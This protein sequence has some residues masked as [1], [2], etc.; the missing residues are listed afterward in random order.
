MLLTMLKI[1]LGITDT[2]YDER[3][4]AIIESAKHMMTSSPDQSIPDAS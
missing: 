2:A 4:L 3:F 1:D